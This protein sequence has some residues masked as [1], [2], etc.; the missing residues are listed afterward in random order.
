MTMRV[1]A[2]L[3]AYTI[4]AGVVYSVAKGTDDDTEIAGLKALLWPITILGFL[5]HL[6]ACAARDRLE[7][8]R[9]AR[10]DAERL[11][12]AKVRR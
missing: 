12:R 1:L 10:E 2:A 3:A 6:I 11:P 8:R 7:A 9:E 4:F 5:G